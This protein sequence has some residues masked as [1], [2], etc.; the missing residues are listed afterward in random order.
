MPSEETKKTQNTHISHKLCH[1]PQVIS[2]KTSAAH[3]R[4]EQ[5]KRSK[6]APKSQPRLPAKQPGQGPSHFVLELKQ[7]TLR[8]ALLK[9]EGPFLRRD[10]APHFGGISMP[11]AR[12]WIWKRDVAL[13]LERQ[14]FTESPQARTE[15]TAIKNRGRRTPVSEVIS[16]GGRE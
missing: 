1:K 8:S 16:K 2:Q 12:T 10:L 3:E 14:K 7:L 15:R 6:R 5:Q 4:H 13:V 11:N 9:Y